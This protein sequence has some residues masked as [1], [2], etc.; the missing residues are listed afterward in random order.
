MTAGTSLIS[1]ENHRQNIKHI[2]ARRTD[3]RSVIDTCRKMAKKAFR[4]EISAV[5]GTPMDFRQ[6]TAIGSRVD[7]YRSCF[8][9]ETQGFPDSPNHPEFPG[10]VLKPGEDYRHVCIYKFSTK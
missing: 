6:P 1:T 10:C 2:K 9:L 7:Q 5:D 3:F 8:A 4:G